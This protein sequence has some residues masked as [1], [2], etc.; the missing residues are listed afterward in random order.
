MMA[1]AKSQRKVVYKITFPNG[2]IYVVKDLTDSITCFGQVSEPLV[3]KDFT[4]KQR[5]DFTVRREIIWESETATDEEVAH[6]EAAYIRALGANDP[7]MGYNEWPEFK[8][9]T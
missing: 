5:R 1:T 9:Q 2:K 3:A 4:R 6:V 8:T 7:K